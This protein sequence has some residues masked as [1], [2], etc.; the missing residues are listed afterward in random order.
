[1]VRFFNAYGPRLDDLGSGRVIPI[2]LKQF[3]M[4]EP[5]TI[6]GDGSQTRTFIY[7]D[8]AVDAVLKVAFCK[9]AEQEAFNIGCTDEMSVLNI[10]K[11]IKKVGKFNSK[12]KFIPHKKVF[13]SKYEDIPRRVPNINKIKSYCNWEPSTSLEDGLK[14][15]IEYYKKKII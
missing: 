8:D 13:G 15:T 11:L 6:H 10:A 3:L 5:I 9:K 7:V 14:R 2:F 4:N 12:F 1:M